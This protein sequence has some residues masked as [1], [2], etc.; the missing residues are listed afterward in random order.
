LRRVAGGPNRMLSEENLIPYHASDLTGRRVLCLAPHPDDETLGCGGALALHTKAQDPV[1]VIFLTD[2]AAGD[3]KAKIDKSAYVRLRRREAEKAC[4]ILGIVDVA[5]WSNADRGLAGSRGALPQM[6][7]LLNDYAPQLVYVPS[8][9]EFHPDHRAACFLLCDAISGHDGDFEV[10]FYELGQPVCI[11]NLID[12]TSVLKQKETAIA[13]YESQLK[14]QP[15]DEL[16]LSL[17]RYRSMTLPEGVTHAEGFSLW[18]ASLI[19]K[20]GVF[21]LPFQ[22]PRRYG[23]DYGEAGPLVS[24]IIRTQDR[25]RLLTHALRSV[26]QQTYA[27]LEVVLV[28][29]GGCDVADAAK[30]LSGEIPITC[31]RHEEKRGR[32]AAANSG[33]ANAKGKYLNF[34]DDDDVFYPQHV[35]TLVRQLEMTGGNV[36][37]S[38]VSNAYFTGPPD[39]PGSREREEIVFNFDYD[40]DRLLFENYIPIM[41]VLFSREAFKWTKGFSEDLVLFEDWDFWIRMSRRFSFEHV[42]K[43]TAEYR[44]YGDTSMA[45]AHRRKYEYDAARALV[46]DRNAAH[47]NGK[48]WANYQKNAHERGAAVRPEGTH[49]TGSNAEETMPIDR[50]FDSVSMGEKLRETEKQRILLYEQNE[51]LMAQKVVLESKLLDL[52]NRLSGLDGSFFRRILAKSMSLPAKVRWLML[53]NRQKSE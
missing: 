18:R 2:G 34:L 20:V 41:G 1:K 24:V 43:I 42:D 8:P 5:F 13:A 45:D 6:I 19:K 38:G 51:V 17:D 22:S 7:A 15:Y 37:Y 25:P 48:A 21:S 11:N 36:A 29:D 44:F 46:F 26:I 4:R 50:S 32:S 16:C 28:N 49:H 33:L 27:N 35:E 10:V 3:S 23:S 30:A 39:V 14:E 53:K 12:I 31:V 52:Q 9:M 40:P 47:L